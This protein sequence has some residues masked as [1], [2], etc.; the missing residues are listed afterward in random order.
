MS[1]GKKV[2]SALDKLLEDPK[3]AKAFIADLLLEELEQGSAKYWDKLM[4]NLK[5]NFCDKPC[6]EDHCC[7]KEE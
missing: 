4:N 6:G 1:I 5:C 7:T 3:R 2:N